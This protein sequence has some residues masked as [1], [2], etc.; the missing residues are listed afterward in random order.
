M[1]IRCVKILESGAHST[2]FQGL[3]SHIYRAQCFPALGAR[4][5][6]ARDS[7]VAFVFSD[8]ALGKGVVIGAEHLHDANG[9]ARSGC[10]VNPQ[11]L[12]PANYFEY[13]PQ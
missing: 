4:V 2:N 12:G 9:K 5:S 7:S 13:L 1:S 10:P 3:P 6:D 11:Y 8:A